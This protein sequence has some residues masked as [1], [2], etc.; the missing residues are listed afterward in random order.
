MASL[1]ALTVQPKAKSFGRLNRT[2]QAERKRDAV[3]FEVVGIAGLTI[4][5]KDD[6]TRFLTKPK[7]QAAAKQL[8]ERIDDAF[9]NRRMAPLSPNGEILLTKARDWMQEVAATSDTGP[10]MMAFRRDVRFD[11]QAVAEELIHGNEVAPPMD[12]PNQGLRDKLDQAHFTL[13]RV[14]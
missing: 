11:A 8:G 14:P 10:K 1:G 3:L 9:R 13:R 2:E 5:L 4:D 7:I 6:T 12:L